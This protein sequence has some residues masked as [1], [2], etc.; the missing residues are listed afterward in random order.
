[1]SEAPPLDTNIAPNVEAEV[2]AFLGRSPT[3]AGS[4]PINRETPLLTS[5]LLDS[6]G[7]LELTTFLASR[8]EIEILDED[9]TP[10][11]F[12]TIGDLVSFV[13]RKRNLA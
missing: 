6:L 8:F 13:V 10:A 11:N 2:I 9:F 3:A 7:I 4:A 12:G 5:G 1:M